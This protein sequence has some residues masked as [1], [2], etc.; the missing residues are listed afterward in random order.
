M[1]RFLVILGFLIFISCYKDESEY[2]ILCAETMLD[3][4]WKFLK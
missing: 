3:E 1:L 2:Q 4:N